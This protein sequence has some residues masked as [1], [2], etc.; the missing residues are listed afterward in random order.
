MAVPSRFWNATTDFSP[1]LLSDALPAHL[2]ISTQLIRELN[3]AVVTGCDPDTGCTAWI[4]DN[5]V[6]L[7]D[8]LD[9]VLS[10]LVHYLYQFQVV[11]SAEHNDIITERTC[12][13]QNERLLS[14]VGRKSSDK[15]QLFFAA[16]HKTGQ[17]HIANKLL[18]DCPGIVR[19]VAIVLFLSV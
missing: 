12:A 11:D 6:F 13:R 5:Y 19:N 4:R 1:C 14:I 10:G 8:N 7:L 9:S 3:V 17:S 2:M 15:I 18:Q 16:L